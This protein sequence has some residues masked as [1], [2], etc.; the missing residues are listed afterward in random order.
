VRELHA[1]LGE[2]EPLFLDR[3]RLPGTDD[4]L[5]IARPAEFDRL[6]DVA[7]NDPEQNLPYW[8]ELWP[9][10][11]AL[12]ARIAR[13]PALVQGKRVLELGC[14]LGMTA[15]VALRAGADLL[16]TDYAP[17]ALWLC[18]LNTLY[19]AGSEPD[20]LRLN[21]RNPNGELF[22]IARD[23]FP[24]VLAADVLYEARDV[25]PLLSLVE[26]IVAPH[27]ELWLAE[28]GRPPAVRFL[29]L[30]AGKGWHI[31]S[32][33]CAG[34]WHDPEDNRNGVV[35]GLHRLTRKG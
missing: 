34:P 8:A 32:K 35:V 1:A 25:E 21:W 27:G 26:R 16:V 3:V 11:I 14:G 15:A 7:V 19:E 4:V 33:S 24:V 12:A 2:V 29:D 13:E 10:G 28:P 5:E 20:A 23:G 9:S 30:I 31:Q 22:D 17:E 6:L 18:A